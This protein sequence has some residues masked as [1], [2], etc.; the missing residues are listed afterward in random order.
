MGLSL[1][2][3]YLEHLAA[4]SWSEIFPEGI[5]TVIQKMPNWNK[6]FRNNCG[7]T[8]L[9]WEF[10]HFDY[11]QNMSRNV[12]RSLYCT[13]PNADQITITNWNKWYFRN[14]LSIRNMLR[15]H[16]WMFLGILAEERNG[17]W[18]RS[19]IL[20]HSLWISI[21]SPYFLNYHYHLC[22]SIWNTEILLVGWKRGRG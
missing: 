11:F 1:L 18:N 21:N 6:Y 7:S 20:V 9:Y 14:I 13:C 4:T 2:E 3:L 19:I 5:L 16:S 10:L 17:G 15:K 12:Y 22:F 8:Y